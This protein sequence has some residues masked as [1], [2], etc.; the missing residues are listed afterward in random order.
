[1]SKRLTYLSGAVLSLCMALPLVAEET[2]GI[3]TV[4]ATVNGT[5]IT[6]GHMVQMRQQLP[7][8][9]QAL[10]DEILFSGILDQL[11]QQTLLQQSLTTPEP[12]RVRVALDNERRALLAGEVLDGIATTSVSDEAL[13]A[14]Y[15]AQFSSADPATEYNASHILVETEEEAIKLA[16]DLRAGADFAEMAKTHSTGPSGPNGGELGWFGPGMMV[17]PFEDAVVGME[18]SQISDPIKTQFGWHV[19]KLNDTRLS[20]APALDEV[21]AEL[22]SE[23]QRKAIETHIAELTAAA[24]VDKS[25]G[26]ALDPAILRND[27]VLEN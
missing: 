1:M 20:D 16:E 19:I 18:K 27:A 10:P 3:D 14:A 7:E 2:P 4:V 24:A 5:T 21:R 23:L 13:Q 9:Y 6:L 15:D 8:Q 22:E 26:T 11:V 17:K 25:A 12:A